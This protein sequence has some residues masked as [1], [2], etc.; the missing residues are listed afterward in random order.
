[1]IT[2]RGLVKT[3]G[4]VRALD[5]LDLDVHAGEVHG[6]LGTQRCRQDDDDPGAA[7]PA[8]GHGG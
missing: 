5:G 1:V 8:A 6:F 2:V 4:S 7:G 3:F